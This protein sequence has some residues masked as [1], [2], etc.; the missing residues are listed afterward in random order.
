MYNSIEMNREFLYNT[1]VIGINS[2]G[3]CISI[4]T[5]N[6]TLSMDLVN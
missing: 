4:K 1:R 2:I 5:N 6:N 3:I